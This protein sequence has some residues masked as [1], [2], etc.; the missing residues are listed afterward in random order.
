MRSPKMHYLR[1]VIMAVLMLGCATVPT[2]SRTLGSGA[3]QSGM[4]SYYAA[5]FHGRPTASGEIFDIHQHTAA[6]RTLPFG[7]RV[8]VT[9]L[10][11]GKSTT[12]RINDRGPF[13][14]GRIIDVSPAAARELDMLHAGVVRVRLDLLR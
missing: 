5:R 11:N 6:H 14:Q 8:C 9:S 2:T 10:V 4:A 12:V 3:G 7:T 1:Y 13:V